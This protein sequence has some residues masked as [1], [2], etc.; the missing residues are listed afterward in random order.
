MAPFGWLPTYSTK[1][2]L[3]AKTQVWSHNK[4]ELTFDEIVKAGVAFASNS[5]EFSKAGV[6]LMENTPEQIR[7]AV[8]EMDDR[9][10]SR[11]AD[12]PIYSD[13]LDQ[14]WKNYCKMLGAQCGSMHGIFVS[15][16]SRSE[17][18]MTI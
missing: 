18:D 17:F 5:I 8:V 4:T 11:I 1:F 6:Q 14:F 3:L 10:N 7:Q 16:Y 12:D 2:L 13:A 15:R 9:I